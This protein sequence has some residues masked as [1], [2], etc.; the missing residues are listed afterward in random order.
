MLFIIHNNPTSLIIPMSKVDENFAT[1]FKR[2]S[3]N[4]EQFWFSPNLFQN[5][6]E[7]DVS[8]KMSMGE[9]FSGKDNFPGLASY[10]R[11]GLKH[12]QGIS[13]DDID[14][15]ENYI[16]FICGRASGKIKTNAT[17]IREYVTGHPDYKKDSIVSNSIA[18]DLMKSLNVIQN[19]NSSTELQKSYH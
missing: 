17:W 13:K 2:G 3:V 18:Y 10:A 7:K 4:K 16:A 5:L 8:V 19:C 1:S 6:G 9:I 11:E 14:Q 12:I 15:V